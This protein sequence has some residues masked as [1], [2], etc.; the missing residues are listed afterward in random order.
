MTQHL[1][2][3]LCRFKYILAGAHITAVNSQGL[4]SLKELVIFKK[5]GYI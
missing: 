2:L 4:T 1:L 3:T 5:I